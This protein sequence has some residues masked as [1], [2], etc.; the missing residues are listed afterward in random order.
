M[1]KFLDLPGLT[2][3]KNKCDALY[4][5]KNTVE[6]SL[7]QIKKEFATKEDL[8]SKQDTLPSGT[9]GQ[10]LTKTNTGIE[11]SSAPAPTIPEATT[12]QAG[13]M[14]AEDK[15]WISRRNKPAL[16]LKSSFSELSSEDYNSSYC[17]AI[18][19]MYLTSDDSFNLPKGIQ[20]GEE[21]HLTLYNSSKNTITITIPTS[22]IVYKNQTGTSYNTK[23]VS[24]VDSLEIEA[25]KYAEINVILL[26]DL[27]VRAANLN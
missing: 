26:G 21:F 15:M 18:V 24:N 16:A 1:K 14:S 2:H 17:P 11:W 3:F 9:A 8:N 6:N 4:I 7:A 19:G 10:V 23:V 25:D 13:L 12:T 22:L 20:Q 27:L 5:D